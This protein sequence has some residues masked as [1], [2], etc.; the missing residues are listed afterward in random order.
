MFADLIHWLDIHQGSM[1]SVLSATLIG[2]TFW[3]SYLTRKIA[4][5][6]LEGQRPYVFLDFIP[7]S[8]R[9]FD[10]WIANDG[11]RSAVA[12]KLEILSSTNDSV[13]Q[14][15]REA[16]VAF[17]RGWAYLAPS[18]VYKY[19]LFLSGE[20]PIWSADETPIAPTIIE[21]RISYFSESGAPYDDTIRFD[22]SSLG[23]VSFASFSGGGE[24]IQRAIVEVNRTLDRKLGSSAGS[25]MV[26]RLRQQQCLFC[27]S[28]I[29]AKA[30]KCSHCLEWLDTRRHEAATGSEGEADADHI[31]MKPEQAQPDSDSGGETEG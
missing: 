10:F 9:G 31:S 17:D 4:K 8:Q 30:K 6:T 1:A 22:L 14:A 23:G 25:S 5:A 13:V 2:V 12:L 29:P 11:S 20:Q 15:M 7:T 19:H 3:Y 18:R 24:D 21:A 28:L 27:G 26:M 16:L